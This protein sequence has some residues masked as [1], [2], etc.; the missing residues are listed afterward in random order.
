MKL[1]LSTLTSILLLSV[2]SAHGQDELTQGTKSTVA[3]HQQ[4][5][6]SQQRV[7]KMDKATLT[8]KD[9]FLDNQRLADLT[10]AYN[11]QLS[12]LVESQ[13]QELADLQMQ[14]DSIDETDRAVLP[15][16][17]QM[18]DNL[19]RF[20]DADLPFL[21]KER[22]QRLEKLRTLVTRADVSVAEKYR[23]ILEAYLVEV[24]YGRTFEAYAGELTL[25]S[26][27]QQ[28]NFLRL[29]RMV[30]YYQ[31]LGGGKSGLWQPL[32]Q[33]WQTL[34]EA[35]N[36]TLRKAI[37]IARQQQIPSLINLPLPKSEIN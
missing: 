22:E 18:V 6:A 24:Q 31:T 17:S 4:N 25:P 33:Q 16:L 14:L 11:Q 29:G 12:L 5:N 10:E 15:M 1:F 35:Q 32:S 2:T 19:G 26:G 13:R 7:E 34:D 37:Q 36:L 28:V 3:R 8:A 27:V 30:L 23:Q 21:P 20:I 9:Q